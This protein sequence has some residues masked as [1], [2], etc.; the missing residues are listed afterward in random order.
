MK[1]YLLLL[2][3]INVTYSFSQN[4]IIGDGF[5]VSDWST[6]DCF[7]SSAGNSRIFITNSNGTG[8][9]YFR[10]V[11][12][13]DGNNSNWGPQNTADKLLSYGTAYNSSDM[14]ENSSKAYYLVA[15]S[16]YNYVFKTREGGNLPGNLGVVIFEVQ[17]EI[18]TVSSV[19]NNTTHSP[20]DPYIVTATLSGSLS[21]G[22]GV[23][24]RYSDD[25]WNTSSVVEMTGS[26]TSYSASI[27]VDVNVAQASISYYIF[28][29]GS[30]LTISA[31]DSDFFTIN[32]NTNSG[33]NY[34][35]DVV[36]T[37]APVI[38]VDGDNPATVELGA[39]YTDAGATADG[40]ETVTT[41]GTVDTS[42][43]GTYTITYSATDAAGNTGTATRTVNVVDTTAPVI[44]LS[45]GSWTN[46]GTTVN[47]IDTSP[48][49]GQNGVF[50]LATSPQTI[51]GDPNTTYAGGGSAPPDFVPSGS[52]GNAYGFC[53]LPTT[54]DP[55]STN[56]NNFN[57]GSNYGSTGNV[58]FNFTG[59][60]NLDFIAYT[61][62]EL[63]EYSYDSTASTLSITISAV[64]A[65]GSEN[66]PDGGQKLLGMVIT[67][68]SNTG[69]GGAVFRT[70]MYWG[71]VK[72]QLSDSSY[73]NTSDFPG[74][75]FSGND[76]DMVNFD[77][78]INQSV[79]ENLNQFP[80][81]DIDQCS[82]RFTK[83]DGT[84]VY[85][86]IN[87]EYYTT[88]GNGTVWNN[89]EPADGISTFDFDGD[90]TVDNYVNASVQNDSWSSANGYMNGDQSLVVD[91]NL[92]DEIVI[93]GLKGSVFVSS[94]NATIRRVDVYQLDGKKLI[95]T[96]KSFIELN[97][98]IYIVSVLTNIGKKNVKVLIN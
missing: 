10:L 24:L 16:S 27:P 39:T 28:T 23:Y 53:L 75:N 68:G 5:G 89:N 47:F 43:V 37:T 11:T 88:D 12:C 72:M 41:S 9:K 64:T 86:A 20:G 91:T 65:A 32:S 15:D 60:T 7:G 82:F 33:N 25:S 79:L 83:A 96:K 97:R 92:L 19:S 8:N 2:F 81:T 85:P 14:I 61:G 52:N 95:S 42:T 77:Y 69:F 26:T 29:S 78:Y 17:G 80:V 1:K 45:G 30:G 76:G 21:S 59:V 54:S 58:T 35:Y 74:S 94:G 63:E 6:T 84:I 98:G 38:T 55:A 4:G 87:V 67:T 66:N 44:T 31:G 49:G 3:L 36:D 46:N 34:S 73:G 50:A 18:R 48:Y 93:Y 90:G 40:G 57:I 62:G 56:P 51:L 70:D 13:W 71:D 22:Q